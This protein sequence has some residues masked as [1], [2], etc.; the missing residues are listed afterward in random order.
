MSQPALMTFRGPI[1][2]PVSAGRPMTKNTKQ[3]R[4][5]VVLYN[6]ISALFRD[7]PAVF[8]AADLLWYAVEGEPESRETPAVLVAFGRP[9][10]DRHLYKQ[11][12]ESGI[13]P[14]VVFEVPSPLDNPICGP[15]T[16]RRA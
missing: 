6:N 1:I 5:S 4:W 2:Y 11:W 16:H 12:Q 10:G 8:V 15:T 9:K 3:L 13:A 14:Q 7:A